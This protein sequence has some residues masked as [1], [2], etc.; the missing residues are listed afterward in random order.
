MLYIAADVGL[1]GT[2]IHYGSLFG[3]AVAFPGRFGHMIMDPDGVLCGCGNRGCWE[4][5]VSKNTLISLVREQIERGNPSMLMNE[6]LLL[7]DLTYEQILSAAQE[8]DVLCIAVFQQIGSYLG[9]GIA[10]LVNALNP[11]VV[12]L[13]NYLAEAG[14]FLLPTIQKHLKEHV[15]CWNESQTEVV[16]AEYGY[17]ACVMGG[18][19]VTTQA[20]LPEPDTMLRPNS[21]P[22]A[23]HP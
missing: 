20:I 18:I 19:V 21:Y 2:I 12:V 14:D 3:G 13:G 16:I 11:E 7:H 10:S 5:Q 17:D 15:V 23:G 4:T 22:I 8:G 6:D 1:G 9:T